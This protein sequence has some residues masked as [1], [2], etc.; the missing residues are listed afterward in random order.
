M[1]IEGLPTISF[2]IVEEPVEY[3]PLGEAH[4]ASAEV[5]PGSITPGES[6]HI[7]VFAQTMSATRSTDRRTNQP[8]DTRTE[9]TDPS[10]T[11]PPSTGGSCSVWTSSVRLPRPN[12]IH[13]W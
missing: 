6:Y 1:G 4:L 11:S 10:P 3:N 9:T 2:P 13:Y 7:A 12:Y 5:A 8:P